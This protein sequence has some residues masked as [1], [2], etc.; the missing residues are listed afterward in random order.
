MLAFA[1]PLASADVV[2]KPISATEADYSSVHLTGEVEGSGNYFWEVSTNGIDWRE[3]AGRPTGDSPLVD[4]L[5]PYHPNPDEPLFYKFSDEVFGTLQPETHYFARL[6]AAEHISP[7]PYLEF[8]TLGPVP[9]PTV[10]LGPVTENTGDSVRLSATV[11]PHATYTNGAFLVSWHFECEPAC[12]GFTNGSGRFGDDGTVHTIEA[13]AEIEPNTDYTIKVVAENAGVSESA[14][15]SF[16]SQSTAPTAETVPAFAYG[17]G[18]GAQIAGKVRAANSDTDYWFE[19]G[20]G[21]AGAPFTG[22]GPMES[23]GSGNQVTL[24]LEEL[25]GLSPD[26]FYHYRVVAESA[27]G[28][29][30][31]E[32]MTFKTLPT[33]SAPPS[34]CP[35]DKLRSETRSEALDECRAYELTTPSDK[36]GGEPLTSIAS[37]AD[38]NRVGYVANSS[39]PGSP[40]SVLT[41]GYMAR[42]TPAGWVSRSMQP[43]MG[44]DGLANNGFY[45]TPEFNQDLTLAMTISGAVTAE[46]ETRNV[47]TVSDD[48]SETWI[49]A[50]T[51]EDVPIKDKCY[52]GR[53]ADGSRLFFHTYQSF[54]DGLSEAPRI[55]EWHDGEVR[56]IS[57]LPGPA[58]EPAVGVVGTGANELTCETNFRGW[59]PEPNVIS[60]DGER[61]F[62]KGGNSQYVTIAGEGS[63][64]IPG[65]GLSFKDAAA[66]G[67]VAIYFSTAE[68]TGDAT[69][70][71]G[72]YEYDVEADELNFISSGATGPAGARVV[73]NA[74]FVSVDGSH[75]YFLARSRLDGAKGTKGGLNLYMGEDGD[76]RYITTLNSADLDPGA[77][78]NKKVATSDGNQF[79]FESVERVTAYDNAG[80]N[81]I[82]RYDSVRHNVT[83]VSCGLNTEP[84]SAEASM[85]PGRALAA[86]VAFPG[87]RRVIS[88]DGSRVLFQTD[89]ALLPADV[90]SVSDVYLYDE[91]R[92]SL[93]STGTSAYSSEVADI[94]A[95]GSDLMFTTR[96][97]LVGQDIDGGARDIYDARVD[98]GFPAPSVPNPCESAD[99]CQLP[100]GAPPQFTPPST[101]APGLGNPKKTKPSRPTCKKKK[102]KASKARRKCGSKKSRG[103]RQSSGKGRSK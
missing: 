51:I 16:H 81:E 65:E 12:S 4:T 56:L 7:A 73:D 64:K 59:L 82:Y 13:E 18:T 43:A 67:T 68:L 27:F 35:N 80:R 49:T 88:A 22:K 99:A 69:P 34:N 21:E 15:T 19:Y 76:V 79:F 10:T 90:N 30:E 100:A 28:K 101:T 44:A 48:G 74:P 38:G 72:L 94:S 95:D 102:H 9:K 70:G 33:P 52:V 58:E 1:V 98:G 62:W 3:V 78:L 47:V 96:D 41:N 2:L 86:G 61:V 29:V 6:N 14:E 5:V 42:R 87:K 66:D 8:T 84:A 63:R 11:D 54:A 75:V 24:Y 37:A 57:V 103:H 93:I 97:A 17:P 50:P 31:G 85:Y 32:D 89:E 40:V 45:Y 77:E 26:S 55:W 92:L 39:F 91:G 60:A 53:S 20:P 25:T 46:P 71:G 36:N 23:A 83:C